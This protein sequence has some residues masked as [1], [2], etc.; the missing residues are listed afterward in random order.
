MRR[1]VAE[2]VNKLAVTNAITLKDLRPLLSK[3]RKPQFQVLRRLQIYPLGPGQYR[4]RG[5]DCRPSEE[6]A[7]ATS[8]CT[9]NQQPVAEERQELEKHRIVDPSAVASQV[10]AEREIGDRQRSLAPCRLNFEAEQLDIVQLSD[11]RVEVAPEK[12][13]LTIGLDALMGRQSLV[14]AAKR[15]KDVSR[16]LC[17]IAK[18]LKHAG[19]VLKGKAWQLRCNSAYARCESSN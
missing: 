4:S 5:L 10:R 17:D 1:N 19:R 18:L 9:L 11:D 2:S 14:E 13:G 15:G 12:I 16:P 3:L 8:R 7:L 6:R